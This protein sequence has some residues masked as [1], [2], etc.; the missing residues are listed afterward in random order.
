MREFYS[1][2]VWDY[3]A[4]QTDTIIWRH[5]LTRIICWLRPTS[6]D[7]MCQAL[8]GLLPREMIA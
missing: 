2:G 7:K 4:T 1:F 5:D 8:N 6:G 3:R